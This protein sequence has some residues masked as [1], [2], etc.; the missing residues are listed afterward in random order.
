MRRQR[1]ADFQR[2]LD[3]IK[4]SNNINNHQE[5][6]APPNNNG[7]HFGDVVNM[8]GLERINVE[9]SSIHAGANGNPVIE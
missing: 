1:A 7:T 2:W 8:N 6:P 3:I 9:P 4:N 5:T